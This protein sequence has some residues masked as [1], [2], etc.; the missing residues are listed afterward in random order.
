MVLK[1]FD[2]DMLNAVV[3]KKSVTNAIFLKMAQIKPIHAQ[4]P[5]FTR[6]SSFK[7]NL[8]F[9]EWEHIHYHFGSFTIYV[10]IG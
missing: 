6:F 3:I 10:D 2:L 5:I 4:D 9:F 7:N 8:L 1:A